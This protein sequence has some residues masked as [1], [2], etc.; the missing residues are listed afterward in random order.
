MDSLLDDRAA[1]PSTLI[2]LFKAEHCLPHDPNI[3][4]Q[5]KYSELQ[6]FKI[7]LISSF[8]GQ[9]LKRILKNF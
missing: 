2:D 7:V 8:K 6:T 5:I 3:I 4:K 1:V 9:K